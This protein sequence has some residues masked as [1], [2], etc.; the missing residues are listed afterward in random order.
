MPPA[1]RLRQTSVDQHREGAVIQQE[2]G[3]RYIGEELGANS[4]RA[5]RAAMESPPSATKLSVG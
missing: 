5:H 2:H 1:F 4:I 3:G